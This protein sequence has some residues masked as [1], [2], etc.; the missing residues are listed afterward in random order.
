[1]KRLHIQYVTMVIAQSPQLKT[2]N[3]C[4]QIKRV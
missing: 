3:I 2:I 4:T 1:M